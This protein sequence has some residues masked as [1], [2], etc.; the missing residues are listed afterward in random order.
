RSLLATGLADVQAM[1][2]AMADDARA[3]DVYRIGQN[4]TRLLLGLGDLIVGWLLLRQA[5]VAGDVLTGDPPGAAF[6]RGKV[7]AARFFAR[8]VIP[9]LAA[10]RAAASC[11][12]GLRSD[13]STR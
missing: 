10:E 5:A 1:V 3:Q 8:T 9:R 12:P 2:A 6:Y 7:A 13:I 4:T 11:A